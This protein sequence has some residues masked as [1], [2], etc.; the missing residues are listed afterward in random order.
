MK[1]SVKGVSR[2]FGNMLDR[3]CIDV[4][5]YHSESLYGMVSFGECSRAFSPLSTLQLFVVYFGEKFT[6]PIKRLYLLEETELYRTD[7]WFLIGSLYCD[8]SV[9][10]NFQNNK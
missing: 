5:I 3:E 1:N 9:S 8:S 2:L 7:S 4:S 10:F 6:E